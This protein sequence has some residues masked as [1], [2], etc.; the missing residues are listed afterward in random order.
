M[1]VTE[2]EQPT[3]VISI[4]SFRDIEKRYETALTK[5]QSKR[6]LTIEEIEDDF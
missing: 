6:K 3:K 1:P 5:V 4:I 2:R